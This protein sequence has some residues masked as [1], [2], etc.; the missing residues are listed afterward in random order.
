M[1]SEKYK[2]GILE[3]YFKEHGFVRHQI[4][5]FNDYIQT[6]IGRAVAE[7]DIVIIQKDLKYK[8]S[9][10]Q[11]YI[12]NPSII[13][14]DRKVRP[15]YPFEARQRDLS[16]DS[17]IFVDIKEELDIE[18]QEPE[19]NY[20]KR[21]LIGRTPIML[22][23]NACNLENLTHDERIKK[24]ECDWDQGGYFIIKG[25]ERVL[26]AQ[27]R[28]IYNQ[29]MVIKQKSGDKYKYICEIRS[30]SE[31]TGHSVLLQAKIGVDG[32]TLVFSLPYIKEVIHAGILFKALGI[33]DENE[34]TNIIKCG[35]NDER[36]DRLLRSVIRDSYHITTQED[37]LR[38]IGQFSIHIIKEEKQ[39]DYARQVVEN[40]LLPHMGITSTVKEKCYL[41]GT[42]INKLIRTF[43]GLRTEDDRDNYKNK[44]VET[45][46]VLCCELF[47]TL[48]K[49]FTKNLQIQLEKKKQRPDVLSLISRTTIITLGLKHSFC[50]PSGTLISMSN[51]LSYPIEKLSEISNDSEKL[52]GWN[53]N[54]G[55]IVTRHG[56]LQEQG[57]KDTIKLT[58]EDGRTLSCTP[59]HKILILN[60][61]GKKEMVESLKIP[62]N[63]R[64]VIGI[65]Y[66]EDKYIDEDL[67]NSWKYTVNYQ[68]KGENKCYTFKVSNIQERNKTLAFMRMLGYLICDGH[69]P[70]ID[71]NQ[72]IVYLRTMFDVNNFINDYKLFTGLNESPLIKDVQTEKW[73]STYLF[74]I[75]SIVGNLIKGIL[76]GKK[77]LQQ[78]TLPTFL[79]DTN[80]PKS[81]IREFLGGL[82]GADGHAPKIGKNIS[83]PYEGVSFSWST[84]TKNLSELKNVMEN[85]SDLLDKLGSKDSY[86]NGPYQ[87]SSGPD[88][89]FYYNLHLQC[90]TEFHKFVGFR[91]CIHKAYKL[92]ILSS[93]WRLREEIM[94]Q[95]DFI[96][97]NVNELK[98]NNKI[99][100]KKA[101]DIS[102]EELKKKEYIL[103]EYY[104]LSNEKDISKRIEINRSSKVKYLQE[105][106][107]IP[108]VR[109]FINNLGALYM[110][111]GEY[112]IER[113]S[114]EIPTFSL[115]LMDIRN[116]KKQIVYDITNVEICKSF[117]AEGVICSNCTGNWGV[118]KNNYVRTGVSQVLSRLTFGATLSHLRRAVIP[119]GKEG[120]NAKI[121]QI[122][123]SQI[124]YI[125]NT[126]TPEG[127]SIGIVLN[128]SLL[129][130]VTQRIPTVVVKEIIETSE[131]LIFINDYNGDNDAT[132]IYLNG[133]LM[134]VTEDQQKFID[135]MK[136]FRKNELLH[137]DISFT[138]DQ[139]D[140]EIKIFCDEGRFTRPLFTLENNK[141][142][143][144]END[145][146][147]WDDLIEKQLIQYVDNSEI[148]QS[149][150]AMDEK[151]FEKFNSNFCEIC[152]TMMMGVMANNI[153][154][155]DHNQCAVSTE[156][157]LMYD[158]SV[159][160]IK[161]VK[162]GDRVITF[163]PETQKQSITKVV[164][165]ITWKTDKEVFKVMTINGRKISTTH[166]H[167]Y[168]TNE[169]WKRLDE[170]QKKTLLGISMEPVPVSSYVEEYN[171]LDSTSFTKNCLERGISMKCIEKY[172]VKLNHI[173]P[174]KSTS[175]YLPIISRMFGFILT[176]GHVR[177]NMKSITLSF[178]NE[179]SAELFEK[180]VEFLGFESKVPIFF[181]DENF[182][183]VF[184]TT[185]DFSFASLFIALG[186]L[187]GKK[188]EQVS[189]EIPSWIMNGSDM[190]K[191][192]FLGGFQGGDGAKIN[193]RNDQIQIGSTQ[194]TI[195]NEYVDSM[196]KM[197]TDISKLF[198]ELGIVVG[199]IKCEPSVKYP[200]KTVVSYFISSSRKNLIKYFDIVNY[201]YDVYKQS[202]SGVLVEYMR[203]LEFE[204][205]NL[206]LPKGLLTFKQW[207]EKIIVKSTTIFLP[208]FSIEK[209]D[210][211]IVSDISVESENQSFLC[212]DFFCIHNSPRN[213][214]Q[215]SMGKQ[216]I[217][218]FANSYQV[219]SDTIVH[220]LDYPQKPL[221]STMPAKFMGFDDM[222]SGINAI[223][224]IMCYTGF[225][226]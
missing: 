114:L 28:G 92:S 190:V 102:R 5:S 74:N 18:G 104:S 90:N 183:S 46:G 195:E 215:A 80:C 67:S 208:I 109:D 95:H 134:G 7:S 204:Y 94:R 101:L 56:G 26:V 97:N 17:P 154:F 38:Y 69:I 196:I 4:D 220:V 111:D 137:K 165:T 16:Y 62:L 33:M 1:L 185:H 147:K 177:N 128:L 217:G 192:E 6:G 181:E 226:L 61:D 150:V 48:F 112:V 63:S 172:L 31:E 60:E 168:M 202:E 108:Y 45:A 160:Q 2:W 132:K 151:D 54:N 189:L 182:G 50:F 103:N 44:R 9:F 122:H 106:H 78:R 162:I 82:F 65:E 187:N 98:E 161:D 203:Y 149:V 36:I 199:D 140:N 136:L 29:P 32:R 127:A 10:D 43:F 35:Y 93:Y 59:D 155:C 135:E 221:V 76:K 157:V 41:F 179:Y 70:E 8:V 188:T 71:N 75:C 184:Q 27:L 34:I 213:I 121:R 193:G 100:I 119:I 118:Q 72:V 133:I 205:D 105:K 125:C 170:F 89:R 116:D 186:M 115:K 144:T 197:M 58:L 194:K 176:D 222:P 64:I 99:T 83:H 110:F 171:V 224:A 148:E 39:K 15:L 23:S 77:V 209:I 169:G 145:G 164:Y 55:L 113:E 200:E 85:I 107:G 21:I 117:L 13:E 73:G 123:S 146:V 153:P 47:R 53:K 180:D 87:S 24:C 96:I 130:T 173:L 163:N 57:F 52:L 79:F 174:L 91:Y 201:R 156:N 129:T 88:D 30:M 175:E 223:V 42:M 84:E 142:K 139:V 138:Y 3:N 14:E 211:T 152:P 124:M 158:G 219:R 40:E 68:L 141:L 159:K 206:S 218:Q 178:D 214:Y 37:A 210:E 225:F 22:R 126:E 198:R 166:D 120:K 216:A 212:G 19:I 51:G 167:P 81:V 131:N 25:K 66:P 207:V 191:R 143:I 11:V 20:H 12:P 49:K 86:I